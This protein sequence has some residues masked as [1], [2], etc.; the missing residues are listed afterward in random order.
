MHYGKENASQRSSWFVCWKGRGN[1]IENLKCG[2]QSR[3][4]N[5]RTGHSSGLVKAGIQ[6]F[7]RCKLL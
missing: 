4:F 1:F 7:L 2:L 3:S 5:A 6:R